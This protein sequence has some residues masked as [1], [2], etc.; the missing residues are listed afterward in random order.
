MRKLSSR[1]VLPSVWSSE[2]FLPPP[3]LPI[4]KY[5]LVSI[6]FSNT[7]L[8]PIY[9]VH[10]YW[11]LRSPSHTSSF[12]F[13]WTSPSLPRSTLDGVLEKPCSQGF[14]QYHPALLTTFPPKKKPQKSKLLWIY[15]IPFRPCSRQ[16]C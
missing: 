4:A 15:P 3:H 16:T 9:P 5:L 2:F 12:S 10:E 14:P 8:H 11:L 13:S 7:F 6:P 1:E